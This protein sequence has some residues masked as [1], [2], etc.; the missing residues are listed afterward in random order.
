MKNILR[1]TYRPRCVF[2]E[3]FRTNIPGPSEDRT[4]LL[5]PP[6]PRWLQAAALTLGTSHGLAEEYLD[7]ASVQR[8]PHVWGFL[9]LLTSLQKSFQPL[10][11]P[12]QHHLFAS[13]IGIFSRRPLVSCHPF[14]HHAD[15]ILNTELISGRRE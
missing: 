5:G 6:R 4:H 13:Q 11:L 10:K 2:L 1:E 15:G 12:H 9:L 8:F 7:L 14:H 3:P